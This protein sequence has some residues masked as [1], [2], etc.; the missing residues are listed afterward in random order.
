MTGLALPRPRFGYKS[1]AIKIAASALLLLGGGAGLV[2]SGGDA[3]AGYTA[4]VPVSVDKATETPTHLS[5]TYTAPKTQ[6][7]GETVLLVL[8]SSGATGLGAFGIMRLL[9]GRLD[10]EGEELPSTASVV[11]TTGGATAAAAT[12]LICIIAAGNTMLPVGAEQEQAWT[13][14]Y[15]SEATSLPAYGHYLDD[16]GNYQYQPYA[17]TL[18]DKN[19]VTQHFK[20]SAIRGKNG[21]ATGADIQKITAEQARKVK[22]AY[23]KAP[24]TR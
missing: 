11:A 10:E 5:Y 23:D 22:A 17:F 16:D 3:I 20:I 14:K 13:G 1:Q 12:L 18:K 19:G 4:P 2:G 15:Y 8:F 24:L 6:D 9:K 21:K 7:L